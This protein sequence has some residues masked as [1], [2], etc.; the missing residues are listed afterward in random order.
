MI[1]RA[2]AITLQLTRLVEL[3]SVRTGGEL[4]FFK[5]NGVACKQL[6]TDLL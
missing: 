3:A 6:A 2:K 4:L 5:A 1:D